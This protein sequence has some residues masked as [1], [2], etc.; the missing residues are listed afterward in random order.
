MVGDVRVEDG[1]LPPPYPGA[2]V[3]HAVVVADFLVLVIGERLA[4]LR[5]IEHRF[6]LGLLVRDYQRAAPGGGNHLV[7]IET[8]GSEV[9]ERPAFLP[10]IFRAEGFGGIF[11]HGYAIFPGHC[12]NLVHLRRHPIEVHGDNRLRLPSGLRH[13]VANRLLQQ[14][15]T[16]VPR[17]LLA[18]N[19]DRCCTQIGNRIGRGAER[20]ALAYHLVAR[21]HAQLYQTQ[22]DGGGAGGERDD[23]FQW[24]I[25]N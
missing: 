19:E 17:I 18:I 9:S 3:A 1:H 22:V 10:P 12:Q 25:E 15:G 8:Q 20:K 5:R 16:H 6:L 4:C 7:T 21:L 2:D 13:P 23:A 11:Q 24:T 14:H